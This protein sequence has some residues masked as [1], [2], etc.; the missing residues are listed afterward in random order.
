[1][2]LQMNECHYIRY[3]LLNK[4]FYSQM[5]CLQIVFLL[6]IIKINGTWILF[7]NA[8]TFMYF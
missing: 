7:D 6:S 4:L 1:M 3:K 8:L 5:F 2:H